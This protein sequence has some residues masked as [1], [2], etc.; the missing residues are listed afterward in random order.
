MLQRGQ[1]LFELQISDDAD[2]LHSYQGS[3]SRRALS[4]GSSEFSISQCLQSAVDTFSNKRRRM[5]DK[6]QKWPGS[7][8]LFE[9][10]EARGSGG[11]DVAVG[12]D[13]G[14]HQ[15]GCS[16]GTIERAESNRH[17]TAHAR[18]RVR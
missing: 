7:V 5:S 4:A 12:I 13:E 10:R 17:L 1:C 16:L 11:C 2:S 6:R 9:L 18:V 3:G 14:A 15:S 8:T